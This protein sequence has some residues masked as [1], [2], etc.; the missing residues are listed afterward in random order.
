MKLNEIDVVEEITAEDFIKN[1]VKPNK[2]VVIKK[3]SH[4]WPAYQK[5]NLDYF[6]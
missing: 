3:L 2:P 1:Y 5:W 6:F 4:Q